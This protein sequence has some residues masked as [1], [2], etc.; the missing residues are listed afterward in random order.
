MTRAATRAIKR[1]WRQFKTINFDNGT[2]FHD[3]AKLEARLPVKVYFATPYNS[4]ERGSNENFNGLVRQ[5]LAK[6]T[7]MS[8]V[9]QAQCHHIVDD[10][11]KR[12]RKRLGFNT[13]AALYY[14]H[15][16]AL[17]LLVESSPRVRDKPLRCCA[18]QDR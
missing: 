11:N 4:W 1:H 18:R 6:R 3:Y 7:C 16:L 15:Q 5:Y 9:T 14:R 13:P 8:S 10:L 17:H 2:E 12:P